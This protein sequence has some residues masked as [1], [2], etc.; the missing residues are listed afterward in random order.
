MP[1]VSIHQIKWAWIYQPC[2]T[3]RVHLSRGNAL[4]SQIP[5]CL[6]TRLARHS[7]SLRTIRNC[8]QLATHW[9]LFDWSGDKRSS[10]FVKM[11]SAG[12]S[13]CKISVTSSIETL[14]CEVSRR[15][16]KRRF[17]KCRVVALRKE[18][19]AQWA[20]STSTATTTSMVAGYYVISISTKSIRIGKTTRG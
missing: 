19:N 2:S 11:S 7:H 3:Q 12:T 10:F 1:V 5:H 13:F 15:Q 8:V 6:S 17:A 14:F 16:L 20:S 18:T 9:L 4:I